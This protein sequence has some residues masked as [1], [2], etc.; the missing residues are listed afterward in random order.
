MYATDADLAKYQHRILA[1]LTQVN[2]TDW[3][4][5]HTEAKELIDRDLQVRWYQDKALS[6]GITDAFDPARLLVQ[7][8]LNRL[9]VY[10][11][12]ELI[13]LFLMQDH[14]NEAFKDQMKEF[15]SR[16]ETE[17]EFVISSGLS[18]DW[19]GSGAVSQAEKD[20]SSEF[21]GRRLRAF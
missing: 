9:G 2:K 6:L 14:G 13:Y 7:T 10:K 16:Y 5:Q 20:S 19:D 3:A 18:Y 4:D 8:E 15:K 12:L 1:L 21:V 17:F 11:A